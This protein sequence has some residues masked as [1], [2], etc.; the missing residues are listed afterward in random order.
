MR[1]VVWSAGSKFAL[2]SSLVGSE[3]VTCGA[4]TPPYLLARCGFRPQ[5]RNGLGATCSYL[6]IL[7]LFNCFG[8]PLFG[9]WE[10]GG[11]VGSGWTT[12]SMAPRSWKLHPP[13]SPLLA[14]DDDALAWFAMPCPSVHASLTLLAPSG[15]QIIEY[16]VLL[17]RMQDLTLGTT[18]DMLSWHWSANGAYSAKSSYVVLFFGSTTVVFW[19]LI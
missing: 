4:L 17:C 1:A 5:T 3:C 15:P 2:H 19:K 13:S 14:G 6:T 16:V 9:P 10:T 12:G 18:S 7:R 8:L 11:R